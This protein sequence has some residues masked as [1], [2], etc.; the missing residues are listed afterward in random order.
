MIQLLHGQGPRTRRTA[1]TRAH[2]GTDSRAR[3]DPTLRPPPMRLACQRAR[4]GSPWSLPPLAVALTECIYLQ[5]SYPNVI[6]NPQKYKQN[7]K[8][9]YTH[10]VNNHLL[11]FDG[12]DLPGHYQPVPGPDSHPRTLTGGL[13]RPREETQNARVWSETNPGGCVIILLNKRH[14]F[15]KLHRGTEAQMLFQCAFKWMSHL[16]GGQ[17][18]WALP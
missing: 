5:V 13:P 9:T 18:Q 11:K 10:I 2:E 6:P 7:L 1:H 17:G 12:R 16:T 14:N 15:C 3:V 8:I 4:Y